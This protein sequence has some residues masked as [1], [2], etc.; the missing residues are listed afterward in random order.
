MENE[1]LPPFR[2]PGPFRRFFMIDDRSLTA[3]WHWPISRGLWLCLFLF[4]ALDL[5]AT[6]L[7]AEDFLNGEEAYWSL[8]A[9]PGVWLLWFVGILFLAFGIYVQVW[10][11][12]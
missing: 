6:I 3:N 9:T 7:Y 4:M 10:A 11:N 8:M 12:D 5:L 1:G 2:R